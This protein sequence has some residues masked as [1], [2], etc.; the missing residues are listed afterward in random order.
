MTKT[1]KTDVLIIGRGL[2]GCMT[3]INASDHSAKVAIMEKSHID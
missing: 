3:A 1:I 2:S